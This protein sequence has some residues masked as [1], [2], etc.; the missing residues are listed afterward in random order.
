MTTIQTPEIGIDVFAW[1]VNQPGGRSRPAH[2]EKWWGYE[3]IYKN[4]TQYCMKKLFM[5][6]RGHTSFHFHVNKHE[7]LLVVSGVLTLTVIHDKK[8]FVHILR[9]GE[10]WVMPPGM[11]HRL[12]A[13]HGN[14]VLIEASTYDH[15]NDSVRVE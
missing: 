8:R 12:E 13:A 6:D 1:L 2:V 7:T 14:L 15:P 3:K 5:K 9:E 11:V 4:D 10:A